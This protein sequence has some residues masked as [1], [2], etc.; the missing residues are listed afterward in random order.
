MLSRVFDEFDNYID[1]NRYINHK[2]VQNVVKKQVTR[3][4]LK[5]WAIQKY[6]Q[7][8]IQNVVF[9]AIHS[10]SVNYGDIRLFQVEQLMG[11]ETDICDG[12]DSHFNLMKRFALACG[13]TEQEIDST[14]VA[15]P[16]KRFTDY[17]IKSSREK[18]PVLAMLAIYCNE[19]Q[20][21][22]SAIS[23]ADSLK[24]AYG[25]DDAELEWFR[26]H[27][28]LDIAHADHAKAL[29][30]KHAEDLEDFENKA[31]EV[32]HTAIAEWKNLQDYY[33]TIK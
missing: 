20:T 22:A 4:Q 21:P 13:A 8:K 25:F 9:S 1:K 17:L 26:L 5:K 10:N 29:I 2:S 27:G 19:R 33:A 31:W 12:T 30:M 28:D 16:I 15:T 18:H 3:E 14:P 7:T 24:S 23:L 11:E 32:V 6:H